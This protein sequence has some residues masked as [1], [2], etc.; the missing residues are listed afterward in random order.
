MPLWGLLLCYFIHIWVWVGFKQFQQCLSKLKNIHLLYAPH[1]FHFPSWMR[2]L[3][4]N[5]VPCLLKL[6][7]ESWFLESRIVA[8]LLS[9]SDSWTFVNIV[10]VK[11]SNPLWFRFVYLTLIQNTDRFENNFEH[12][13]TFM[14]IDELSRYEK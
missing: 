10:R 12:A 1:E 6:T 2:T 13:R 5:E 11:W 9:F 7:H 4:N 3:R 14:N 8:V